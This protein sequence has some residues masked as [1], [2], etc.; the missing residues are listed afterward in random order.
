MARTVEALAATNPP[1]QTP[2]QDH[3][4]RA[5]EKSLEDWRAQPALKLPSAA[6][7][8]ARGEADAH[9]RIVVWGDYQDA[10]TARVDAII[11]DFMA[12]RDDV[13]YEFRHFPMDKTCN[14]KIAATVRP[15]ACLA[16]RAAEAAGHVAGADAY[17]RIHASLLRDQTGFSEATLRDVALESGCDFETLSEVMEQ[18]DVLAAI[19]ADISAGYALHVQTTP[20]VFVNEKF[21]PRWKRDGDPVLQRILA[22]AAG[23]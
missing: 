1:A 7:P 19:V 23:D 18:R 10:D 17:W 11:G 16:A 12:G 22:Q 15:R 6:H 3:P 5:F 13:R 21:V 20:A 2:E 4:P 9:V 14:S 8:H